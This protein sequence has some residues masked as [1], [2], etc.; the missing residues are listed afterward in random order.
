MLP[1]LAT[2]SGMKIAFP[3]RVTCTE[4][5][6]VAVSGRIPYFSC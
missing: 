2:A 5:A 4:T 1:D 6:T 3:D